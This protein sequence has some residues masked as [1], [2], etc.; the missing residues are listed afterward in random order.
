MKYRFYS[1]KVVSVKAYGKELKNNTK[2]HIMRAAA[3][4]QVTFGEE[5]SVDFTSVE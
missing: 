5:D 1:L 2:R 3:D 4:A